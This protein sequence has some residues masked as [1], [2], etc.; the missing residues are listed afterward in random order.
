[1]RDNLHL[2]ASPNPK[3]SNSSIPTSIRYQ[4]FSA[5]PVKPLKTKHKHRKKNKANRGN[6]SGKTRTKTG[7]NKL[8]SKVKGSKTAKSK[9]TNTN[10]N[11]NNTNTHTNTHTNTNTETETKNKTPKHRNN[12]NKPKKSNTFPGKS[13]KSKKHNLLKLRFERSTSFETNSPPKTPHS[14]ALTAA[15][16]NKRSGPASKLKMK[17]PK[18]GRSSRHHTSSRRDTPRIGA[19]SR[20]KKQHTTKHKVP[21]IPQPPIPPKPP[22]TSHLDVN[23][24]ITTRDRPPTLP[25]DVPVPD[26]VP[27]PPPPEED[28]CSPPPVPITPVPK[29]LSPLAMSPP[30][31]ELM[32]DNNNNNN[33]IGNPP[34]PKQAPRKHNQLPETH[35]RS[36][37]PQKSPMNNTDVNNFNFGSTHRKHKNNTPVFSPPQQNSSIL[38]TRAFSKT[39]FRSNLKV[40]D[41]ARRLSS[42]EMKEHTPGTGSPFTSAKHIPAHQVSRSIPATFTLR[43]P[44][45]SIAV[46]KNYKSNEY[47]NF[48]DVEPR[49]RH[50]S[51]TQDLMVVSPHSCV[52][53]H[54]IHPYNSFCV[55]VCCVRVCCVCVCVVI[56]VMKC[57]A[58]GVC[59]WLCVSTMCVCMCDF[60]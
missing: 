13:S 15:I 16:I 25:D 22:T 3:P 29:H 23:E 21:E 57:V 37:P 14:S 19:S 20:K 50:E 32:F 45:F 18:K 55:C 24:V 35:A 1:V 28:P 52:Y 43:S 53:V 49:G 40:I 36:L 42:A 56:I 60:L 44:T 51:F 7:K 58:E 6:K 38:P 59:V 47:D 33:N 4:P 27:P 48:P 9:S 34:Q 26:D 12:N 31:L 8:K 46:G 5:S 39:T 30:Q 41:E 17:R 11:T 2:F 54:C 10:T